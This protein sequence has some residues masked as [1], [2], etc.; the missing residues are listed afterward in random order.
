MKFVRTGKYYGRRKGDNATKG[1]T[2]MIKCN[3]AN[4]HHDKREAEVNARV[5][6]L[7]Q[8]RV[9]EARSFRELG[10]ARRRV[11][12]TSFVSD[13]ERIFDEDGENIGAVAIGIVR[14]HTREL[15][16]SE[17]PKD[18]NEADG[19]DFSY[20]DFSVFCHIVIIAPTEQFEETLIFE[21]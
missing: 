17:H 9:D 4:N 20:F 16:N 6:N 3:P 8:W 14:V 11:G 18:S 5:H 13:L 21:K 15:K 12:D 19:D 10:F 2:S 7:A 1:V